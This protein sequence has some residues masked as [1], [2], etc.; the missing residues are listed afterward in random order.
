MIQKIKV[1]T[2]L[3][4]ENSEDLFKKYFA[5]GSRGLL[6]EVKVCKPVFYSLE[7]AGLL[8]CFGVF[9]DSKLVGF[10]IASTSVLPHYSCLGTTI[11]SIYIDKEYRKFGTAK[12]LIT[13]VKYQAVNR[14]AKLLMLSS[15]IDSKFGN[16]AATLGFK[17]T[18]EFYGKAL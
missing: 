10:I 17:K 9:K 2:I 14:G 13:R 12:E 18:N 6:P 8:D 16:F 4:S 15:P 5:E 11:M 3:E 1:E 7:Q